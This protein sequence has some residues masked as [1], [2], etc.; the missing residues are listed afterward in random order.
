MQKKSEKDSSRPG[1]TVR[2]KANPNRRLSEVKLQRLRA[3]MV[4]KID[5]SEIPKAHGIKPLQRDEHG[6]LPRRS[7]IREAVAEEMGRQRITVYRLW[8]QAKQ[9]C[10]TLSQSAVSEF[11]KGKRQIELPYA[12]ALMAAMRLRLVHEVSKPK[13]KPISS[14]QK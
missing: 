5:Y 1:K 3:A 14:P 13:R 6:N 2:R 9:H 11:L 4:E 7:P 10:P 8:K 12:E